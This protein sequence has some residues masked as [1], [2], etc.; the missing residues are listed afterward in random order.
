M[1]FVSDISIWWLL[2]WLV[3][4]LLAARFFYRKKGWVSEVDTRLR[5]VFIGLRAGILFLL[6]ILLI[7]LLLHSKTYRKEQPVLITVVDNSA[8]MLN[9][10]DSS[11]VK[12]KLDD[13]VNMI[14]ENFDKKFQLDFFQPIKC[15]CKTGN[16]V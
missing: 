14:R 11:T 4:C 8:S 16:F 12:D 7:G 13:L 10:G 2:P 3:I 15:C 1:Q 9:Y 6:G 5:L